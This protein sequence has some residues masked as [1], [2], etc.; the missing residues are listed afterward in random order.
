MFPWSFGVDD[1][2]DV[3]SFKDD[4]AALMLGMLCALIGSSVLNHLVVG[5]V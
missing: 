3:N 1:I 5:S 2:V 4:P